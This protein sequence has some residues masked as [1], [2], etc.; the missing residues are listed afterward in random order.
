MVAH[1]CASANRQGSACAGCNSRAG[2]GAQR[3]GAHAD[4]CTCG[5]RHLRPQASSSKRL[6]TSNACCCCCHAGTKPGVALAARQKLRCCVCLK[7]Q[8]R[9]VAS[10]RPSPRW[11]PP[12]WPCPGRPSSRLLVHRR[13]LPQP[14]LHSVRADAFLVRNTGARM[15]RVSAAAGRPSA[16]WCFGHRRGGTCAGSECCADPGAGAE[17]HHRRSRARACGHLQTEDT[18]RRIR[19]EAHLQELQ[20]VRCI[21]SRS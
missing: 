19:S 7:L 16:A 13:Q 4:R 15:W 21:F 20:H 9:S 3:C 5:R 14:H 18:H 2:C 8:Q 12:S 10:P 1:C 17:G 6:P 11:P